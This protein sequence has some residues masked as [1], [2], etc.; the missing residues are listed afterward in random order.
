MTPFP[1]PAIL[2]AP[3]ALLPG[4]LPREGSRAGVDLMSYDYNGHIAVVLTALAVV[5]VVI[6]VYVC[7]GSGILRKGSRRD[8]SED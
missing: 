8:H 1:L 2:H 5:D 6:I 7:I 3:W 4:A